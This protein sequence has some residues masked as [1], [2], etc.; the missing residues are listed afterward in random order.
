MM[1]KNKKKSRLS[2]LIRIVV[3]SAC[4]LLNMF[5]TKYLWKSKVTK[6]YRFN[7]L[8]KTANNYSEYFIIIGTL[9][10]Q[11]IY[12]CVDL[13]EN[14]SENSVKMILPKKL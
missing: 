8:V 2:F 7:K 10:A 3:S 14:H 11:N 1:A 13:A 4:G 9:Q 5:N 6:W 12:I